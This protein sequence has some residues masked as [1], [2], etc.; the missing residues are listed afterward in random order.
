[1]ENN[2][3]LE[4]PQIKGY[5][6]VPD[7]D[8]VYVS[9]SGN[10]LG[11]QLG[12]D[13][14]PDKYTYVNIENK[15]Y[16]VHRLV[17]KT[18]LPIPAALAGKEVI[19]N[20]KDG[21]KRNNHVDNLEW[22]DYRHNLV[23]AYAT[24][25]KVDV[26]EVH[27]MDI[28]TREVTIYYSLGDCARSF[29]VK[30]PTIHY[31]LRPHRKIMIHFGHYVMKDRDEPWPNIAACLANTFRPSEKKPVVVFE[32]DPSRVILFDTAKQA[33][34]HLKVTDLA[35]ILKKYTRNGHQY[36][37]V[38]GKKVMYFS[39]CK[40][41]LG[42]GYERVKY[43]HPRTVRGGNGGGGLKPTEL[44]VRDLRT[45]EIVIYKSWKELAAK[46]NVNTNTLSRHVWRTK[47][48]WKNVLQIEYATSPTNQ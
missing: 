17:A 45:N 9:R 7:T 40:E 5:Y 6:L 30:A 19:I 37:M 27:V 20:H 24:G 43:V 25:L 12:V 22:C 28:R 47:G 3:P 29:D 44:R 14:D 35:G 39:D 11:R 8:N 2:Q 26:R 16:L 32:Y 34:E 36:L 18:F 41:P 48:N 23:H 21:N 46:L 33:G 10:I 4:H 38:D 13:V 31:C 1:M 42:S 15:T